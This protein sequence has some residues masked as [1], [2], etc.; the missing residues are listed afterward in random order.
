MAKINRVEHR[1]L[2]S[3]YA[4]KNPT[5]DS[6][7]S[8]WKARLILDMLDAH[9]LKPT[10]IADVG[11]G[12]GAVL[13]ELQRALP[14]TKLTGFDIAPDAQRFW[15]QHRGIEFRLGD[16]FSLSQCHYD[17]MLVL[18]VVEHLEHPFSFLARLRTHADHFV[19]HFPLDLSALSVLREKPLL[20]VRSK[21]GHLHYYTRRLALALLAECGFEVIDWRYTGATFTAPR[22]TWKTRLASVFRRLAYGFSRDLGARLLGGETLIVL[23][24][25]GSTP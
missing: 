14:G 1:Y 6:E 2:T 23:A 25:P 3:D 22:R 24:R 4:E 8:P 12:A 9:G 7:D 15:E 5:W 17:V 19:F 16:F 20:Y 13:A 21:V 11:C 10:H 18:D